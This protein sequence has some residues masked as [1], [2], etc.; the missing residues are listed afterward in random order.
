MKAKIRTD[1][2]K[3]LSL[4]AQME[5][6]LPLGYHVK[7]EVTLHRWPLFKYSLSVFELV[8]NTA[9]VLKTTMRPSGPKQRRWE[10]G[11]E[12]SKEN[13]GMCAFFERR[14]VDLKRAAM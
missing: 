7:R 8:S 13:G 5:L 3:P 9:K 6:C 1:S 2:G 10:V 11:E 12:S 4:N 14:G